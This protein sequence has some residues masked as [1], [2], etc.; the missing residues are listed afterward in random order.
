M[1]SDI[2]D[3]KSDNSTILSTLSEIISEMNNFIQADENGNV[4][5]SNLIFNDSE[6][7]QISLLDFYNSF[8]AHISSYQSLSKS[9]EDNSSAI[10]EMSNTLSDIKIALDEDTT[11]I[12][13]IKSSLEEL[14][15]QLTSIQQSLEDGDFLC[16]NEDNNLVLPKDLIFDASGLSDFDFSEYDVSSDEFSSSSQSLVT[17]L[18]A[19]LTVLSK[20]NNAFKEYVDN[21]IIAHESID[22]SI[23]TISKDI[24]NLSDKVNK[25]DV[26]LDLSDVVRVDSEGNINSDADVTAN[27]GSISLIS[28]YTTINAIQN[29]TYEGTNL[30][31]KFASEIK[32]FDD[33]WAWIKSRIND[34]NYSGIFV[35][36]YISDAL[37]SGSTIIPITMRILG[38]D[39]YSRISAVWSNNSLAQ[40]VT[41][42]IDFMSDERPANY[43]YS[44]IGFTSNDFSKAKIYNFLNNTILSELSSSL[45]SLISEKELVYLSYDSESG[46]VRTGRS[47]GKLWL[48]AWNEI[49]CEYPP[50]STTVESIQC[51]QY[52]LYNQ[53]RMKFLLNRQTPLID[54]DASS[55]TF[56][57][58][59]E[60]GSHGKSSAETR[61]NVPIAFRISA[62]S[63]T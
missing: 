58:I 3:I 29:Q 45:Q 37:V 50:Y 21:H 33:V 54:I 24:A 1:S 4:S 41:H 16:L 61:V 44:S 19:L 25:I 13:N 48:P 2:T 55:G 7:T 6:G 18:K 59:D 39:C 22:A 12:E 42:H 34:G 5:V 17:L 15:T 46:F 11:D 20:V 63:S 51:V 52:P 47:V 31:V 26:S 10:S 40:E 8:L 49:S 23:D 32:S 38:I 27:M 53:F 36:D 62:D 60:F 57:S 14:A 9:V 28:L 56:E 35:G 30:S 43:Q